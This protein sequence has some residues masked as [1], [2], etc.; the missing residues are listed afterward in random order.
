MVLVA[1]CGCAKKAPFHARYETL[2]REANNPTEK[3]TYTFEYRLLCYMEKDELEQHIAITDAVDQFKA[4]MLAKAYLDENISVCSG[5]SLPRKDRNRWRIRCWV[6][7]EGKEIPPVYVDAHTGSITC[8]GNLTVDN[9]SDFLTQY[10]ARFKR[11]NQSPEPKPP[12][13][14]GDL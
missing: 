4:W 6:G 14:K 8:E 5:I 11:H 1:L 10:Y 2:I 9:P 3:Q 13:N 12:R 7:R